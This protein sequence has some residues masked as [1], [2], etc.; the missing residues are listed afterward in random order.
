MNASFFL[1][2]AL[3][4]PTFKKNLGFSPK[5]VWKTVFSFFVSESSVT[6]V[7][8]LVTIINKNGELLKLMH[9]EDVE[10]LPMRM[11]LSFLWFA[12]LQWIK[13]VIKIF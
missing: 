11:I 4:Y 10:K 1:G 2:K 13:I 5:N 9:M 3:F 6:Y 7:N 8:I 12:G